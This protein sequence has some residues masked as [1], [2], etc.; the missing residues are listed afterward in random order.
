MVTPSDVEL[1]QQLD[2]SAIRRT[3]AG[4]AAG[5]DAA[6]AAAPTLH[7][8]LLRRLRRQGWA[9]LAVLVL[10]ETPL[11]ALA[12][13]AAA[14]QRGD[15]FWLPWVVAVLATVALLAHVVATAMQLSATDPERTA[16]ILSRQP[17]VY[18]PV[19]TTRPPLLQV[20]HPWP[21]PRPAVDACA[22]PTV[23][24]WPCRRLSQSSPRVLA[25]AHAVPSTP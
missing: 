4:G 1:E 14:L 19:D 20:P 21:A 18:I 12:W 17:P 22:R 23:A 9:Q 7:E 5:A 24:A 6:R 15:P 2:L 8:Q 10:C 3:S 11:V 13:A 25:R 16:R